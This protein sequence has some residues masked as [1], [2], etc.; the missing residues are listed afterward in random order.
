M[1][2]MSYPLSRTT[3]PEDFGACDARACNDNSAR[4]R[5]IIHPGFRAAPACVPRRRTS[6]SRPASLAS[7]N[8]TSI[9]NTMPSKIENR[10]HTA[11]PSIVRFLRCFS[12]DFSDFSELSTVL[13]FVPEHT[14]ITGN[15]PNVEA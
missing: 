14:Q 5:N 10:Q 7:L 1:N 8:T 4:Q 11:L 15:R 13:D 2:F 9:E 3:S 12:Y 6:T